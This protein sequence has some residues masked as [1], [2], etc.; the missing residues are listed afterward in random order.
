MKPALKIVS[1]GQTGVD[2]AA[3]D[4]ALELGIS[5]GGWC[6]AGRRAED[7]PIDSRYPLTETKTSDYL[8]R[9]RLNVKDSDAS[10]IIYFDKV[11]GGTKKTRAI[12][13]QLGKPFLL[14][15]M[16]SLDEEHAL[17]VLHQ[18]IQEN[19]VRSLNV[20]GPRASKQAQAHSVTHS[21]I[22]SL[23]KKN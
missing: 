9:T 13:E 16:S 3:L 5:C 4:A 7:G 22:S 12:C 1:G 8:E 18:F 21:L 15:D 14:L 17:S 19:N 11:E 6:P 23:L 20:A 2:R 10:L